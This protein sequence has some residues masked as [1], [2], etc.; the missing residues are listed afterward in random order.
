MWTI[1]CHTHIE[2]GRR[3]V[4][5]TSQTMEKRW[6]NHI[7]AAKSSK[8]GRWYFPNAIRKYG[9]DAFSH[10]VLEVC[11]S[12]EKAN[13]RENAWIELFESRDPRFGF[14]LAKGGQ[15]KPGRNPW[16]NLEFRKNQVERTKK[17]F[18]EPRIRIA[19]KIA[20][21]TPD[22]RKKK[23][24]SRSKMSEETIEKIL[25]VCKNPSPETR[26]KLSK[27]Y[28]PQIKPPSDETKK[29]IS[30][31]NKGKTIS[32][33]QKEKISASSKSGTPEI[34]K[35]ISDSMKRYKEGVRKSQSTNR[36]VR[37]P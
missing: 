32:Q 24:L 20:H 21:G 13:L 28:R 1:Y 2:S 25:S 31:A 36:T 27:G 37:N 22:S 17:F 19:N 30:I 6:K 7:C 34:R 9:K 4:G 14:N 10:R 26:T 3:Y 12:L 15:H 29:K 11:D 8:N 5:Q 35:K 23:S 33:E 18:N 16:D